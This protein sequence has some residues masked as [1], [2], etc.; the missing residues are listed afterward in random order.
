MMVSMANQVL[1]KF[2]EGIEKL[3]ASTGNVGGNVVKGLA[4]VGKAAT[5]DVVR[6]VAS[7]PLD[8]LKGI[9]GGAPAPASG[10]KS[11]EV[12]IEP[13]SGGGPVSQTGQQ[14]GGD[15]QMSPELAQKIEEDRRKVAERLRQHRMILEQERERYE[16]S[17]RE[18]E[19]DKQQEELEK[20]EEQKDQI[21]QIEVKKKKESLA[22]TNAKQS[23]GTAETGKKK[24]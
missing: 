1:G 18:D 13:V 19:E 7:A 5:V 15:G 6:G 16:E 8:I 24:Y 2:D 20:H 22:V 11:G 14:A 3:N 12:G 23:G 9:L 4:D 10:D 17:K 21:K